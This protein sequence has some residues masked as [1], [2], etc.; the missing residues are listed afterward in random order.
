MESDRAGRIVVEQFEVAPADEHGQLNGSY[1]VRFRTRFVADPDGTC[2]E[3]F[4]AADLVYYPRS[5]WR[6][7]RDLA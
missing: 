1:R 7:L 3:R 5:S 2:T 6:W 4:G